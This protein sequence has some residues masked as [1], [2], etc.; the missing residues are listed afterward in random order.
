MLDAVRPADPGSGLGGGVGLGGTVLVDVAAVLLAVGVR[1]VLGRQSGAGSRVR[2]RV[3]VV[4][5][6]LALLGP[7]AH[8]VAAALR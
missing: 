5:A 1:A 4:A 2:G 6:H 7:L 3:A 8:L